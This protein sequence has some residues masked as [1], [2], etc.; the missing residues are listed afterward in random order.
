MCISMA[1]TILNG[2]YYAPGRDEFELLP[3]ELPPLQDLRCG[4]LDHAG[5]ARR[6]PTAET[7]DGLFIGG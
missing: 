1:T 4:H 3:F 2:W 6:T 7:F 5:S